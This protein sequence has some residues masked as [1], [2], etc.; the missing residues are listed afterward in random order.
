MSVV[1]RLSIC[2]SFFSLKDPLVTQGSNRT[3]G[4]H[5][6][7]K[8]QTFIIVT[9]NERTQ[10]SLFWLSPFPISSALSFPFFSFNIP[11]FPFCLI[12]TVWLAKRSEK[13]KRAV[14]SLS[15]AAVGPALSRCGSSGPLCVWG[16]FVRRRWQKS[17]PRGWKA[18]TPGVPGPQAS[19]I[20]ERGLENGRLSSAWTPQCSS[21]AY[22]R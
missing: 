15:L 17:R 19:T 1:L 8:G 11:S 7:A 18:L 5:S 9:P 14:S 22:F 16:W 2:L 4:V 3:V 20:I 21:S 13:K 6:P 10:T 12:V